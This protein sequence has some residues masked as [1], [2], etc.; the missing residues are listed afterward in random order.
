MK[1][2]RKNRKSLKTLKFWPV[3]Y[4]CLIT[5]PCNY[6]GLRIAVHNNNNNSFSFPSTSITPKPHTVVSIEKVERLTD[7]NKDS[8]NVVVDRN[9]MV[10]TAFLVISVTLLLSL[11]LGYLH[12]VST[13]KHCLMLY[14]Y[15]EFVR[16]FLSIFW[17]WFI[18]VINCFVT[19]N[20]MTIDPS[21]AKFLSY[22]WHGVVLHFLFTLNLMGLLKF[23][24]TKEMVLDPSMP[25]NDDD[26]TLFK[27]LRIGSYLAS[28]SLLTAMYTTL[29][30]PKIYYGLVGDYRPIWEFPTGTLISFGIVI[31]LITTYAI[32]SIG[33]T[34]YQKKE[35]EHIGRRFPDK[36]NC[37]SKMAILFGFIVYFGVMINIFKDGYLWI[38]QTLIASTLGI[39]TRI[40]LSTLQLKT[41]VRKV[42]NRSTSE[43]I[44]FLHQKYA[45][46]PSLSLFKFS[47]QIQPIE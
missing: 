19:G 35:G 16:T 13:V 18:I 39:L 7:A 14:L 26:L 20:G 34:F 36:L 23:Y 8:K 21:S 9:F 22:C 44:D 37:L 17:I 25:W 15:L 30:H 1:G 28:A 11:I 46:I 3:I 27:K 45:Q 6:S 5:L 38:V 24:M 29:G 33:T 4:L 40:I 31:F 41:Y 32:I 47:S 10:L 42:I 2:R 12:S 43:M